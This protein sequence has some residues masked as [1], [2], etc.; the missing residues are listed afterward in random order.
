MA[1]HEGPDRLSFPQQW[2]GKNRVE[3]ELKGH[4]PAGCKF[5]SGREQIVDVDGHSIQ[6]GAACDNVAHYR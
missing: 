3:A 5:V 2:S 6:H 1:D 4:A